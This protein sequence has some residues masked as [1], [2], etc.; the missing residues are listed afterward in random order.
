[1]Q[2]HRYLNSELDAAESRN[3][4]EHFTACALCSDAI[5]AL[6]QLSSAQ[7]LELMDNENPFSKPQDLKIVHSKKSNFLKIAATILLLFGVS[8]GAYQLSNRHHDN[9]EIAQNKKPIAAEEQKN[10]NQPITDSSIKNNAPEDC[11]PVAKPEVP[12]AKSIELNKTE[13][14]QVETIL[15]AQAPADAAPIAPIAENKSPAIAEKESEKIAEK[16]IANKDLRLDND[17]N[18]PIATTSHS[19]TIIADKT[20][21]ESTTQ[22]TAAAPSTKYNKQYIGNASTESVAASDGLSEEKKS[23]R[24]KTKQQIDVA[25]EEIKNAYQAKQND[26]VIRKALQYIKENNSISNQ[27]VIYYLAMSYYQKNDIPNAKIYLNQIKNSQTN[28]GKLAIEQLQK[29]ESGN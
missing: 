29:I 10:I 4:E 5:D 1:M 18:K 26:V 21:Y 24:K 27:E 17:L 11:P 22:K 2:L 12:T 3:V 15:P 9:I 14:A 7:R 8:L 13:E 19:N 28:F 23:I 25:L 20:S 16:P 6:S